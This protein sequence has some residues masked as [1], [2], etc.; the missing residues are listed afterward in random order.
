M[1]AAINT[2]RYVTVQEVPVQEK[3]YQVNMI[4]VK[5]Q[6]PTFTIKF[7]SA[8]SKVNLLHQHEP[9]KPPKVKETFSEDPKHVLRHR[10]VRPIINEIYEI[11]SPY[12]RVVRR[13]KPVVETIN[14]IIAGTPP[15]STSSLSQQSSAPLKPLMAFDDNRLSQPSSPATPSVSLLKKV[16]DSNVFMA[17]EKLMANKNEIEEE[18]G[19]NEEADIKHDSDSNYIEHDQRDS[20]QDAHSTEKKKPDLMFANEDELIDNSIYNGNAE[21]D[22]RYASSGADKQ[23]ILT[24]TS[25]YFHQDN[26]VGRVYRDR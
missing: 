6:S 15:S 7:N 9:Q 20:L 4:E 21:A 17:R 22:L 18:E 13:I 23:N 2:R 12:R 14:T 16:Y 11:I 19:D 26:R 8:S 5:S 3:H 24:M 10:V 25:D 1:P